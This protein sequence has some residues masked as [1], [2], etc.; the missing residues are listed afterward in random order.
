MIE[1]LLKIREREREIYIYIYIYASK[2]NYRKRG[3]F[4]KRRTREEDGKKLQCD[5]RTSL[6]IQENFFHAY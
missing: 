5:E 1:I 4:R 6:A 3:E 2:I